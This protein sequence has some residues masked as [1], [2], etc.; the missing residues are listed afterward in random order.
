MLTC[1]SPRRSAV[2]RCAWG[3][4]SPRGRIPCPS[5]R[6][7]R[8]SISALSAR[9][10]CPPSARGPLRRSRD[11]M[12]APGTRAWATRLR[13]RTAPW[14]C[15]AASAHTCW[16]QSKCLRPGCTPADTSPRSQSGAA[17]GPWT[18]TNFPGWVTRCARCRRWGSCRRRGAAASQRRGQRRIVDR[19]APT[20]RGAVIR[21]QRPRSSSCCAP[22]SEKSRRFRRDGQTWTSPSDDYG[23]QIRRQ[24]SDGCRWRRWRWMCSGSFGPARVPSSTSSLPRM[25]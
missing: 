19:R 1:R 7:P 5:S 14:R 20:S 16:R 8:R 11:A 25:G 3:R 24:A 17:C 21:S 4:R 6:D 13:R 10:S 22:G 15:S 23:C 2:V 9:G 12:C 18:G